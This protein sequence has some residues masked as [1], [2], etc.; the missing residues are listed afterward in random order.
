MIRSPLLDMLNLK[1]KIY[2]L[3]LNSFLIGQKKMSKEEFKGELILYITTLNVL[4]DQYYRSNEMIHF[5]NSE[6]ISFTVCDVSV[7]PQVRK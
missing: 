6:K 5:L 3:F 7:I 2:L 4:R 1:F